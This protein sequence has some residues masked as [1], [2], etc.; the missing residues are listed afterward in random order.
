MSDEGEPIEPKFMLPIIPIFMV[1]SVLGIATG[2]STKIPNF[3]LKDIKEYI[4]HYLNN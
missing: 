4:I 3:K 2:F 1:N